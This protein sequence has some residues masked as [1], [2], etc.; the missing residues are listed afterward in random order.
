[1]ETFK[2]MKIGTKLIT[3]FLLVV[4]IAAVIG[5][6]GIIKIRQIDAADTKLYE[7][8]TVPL[9]DLANM[10]ILFQRVRINLRDI[11]ELND[12]KEQQ[13]ALATLN[14]LRQDIAEHAAKFEKTILTEEAQRIFK[15]YEGVAQGLWW[16]YRQGSG[17]GQGR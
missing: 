16:L 6:M 3:A 1:M 15:E 13:A 10:S 17:I 2:N 12:T 5:F 4:A 11:V 7:K 9:G 8:I 14:Q